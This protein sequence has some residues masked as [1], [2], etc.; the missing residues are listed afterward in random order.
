MDFNIYSCLFKLFLLPVIMADFRQNTFTI[1]TDCG[2]TGF[3]PG[4]VSAVI[5]NHDLMECV[6][7][8]MD[9]PDCLSMASVE[10]SKIC[11]HTNVTLSPTCAPRQTAPGSVIIEKIVETGPTCMNG[12][13]FDTLNDICLCDGGYVGQHCERLAIDCAELSE[14]PNYIGREG[15]FL[16]Q[17]TL[18]PSPFVV[19]CSLDTSYPKPRLYIQRHF[20][21]TAVFD[22]TWTEYAEG[23]Y[24]NDT[25]LWLGNTYQSYITRSRSDYDLIIELAGPQWTVI[26]QRA[27]HGFRVDDEA[28]NFIMTF[29]SSTPYLFPDPGDSLIYVN[30][31]NFTTLDRDMDGIP[32]SHC[33]DL[34]NSGFWF[35]AGNK[36][37][38][39]NPNGLLIQAN[40]EERLLTEDEVFWTYDMALWSP[41]YVQMYLE[42]PPPNIG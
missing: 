21:K 27:Y 4:D 38:H 13:T 16:I 17:P 18:S 39:C 5:P 10:T 22:K 40:N 28:D 8:C 9:N 7:A 41:W 15:N 20:S 42:R 30:G 6:L 35:T 34:R 36:C 33:G 31:S 11:T 37:G 24:F 2:D 25:N 26:K 32:G 12:G 19:F 14:F 1:R 23:F 3:Q 29:Q